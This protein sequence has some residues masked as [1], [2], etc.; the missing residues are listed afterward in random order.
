MRRGMSC[1]QGYIEAC[2]APQ[3]REENQMLQNKTHSTES[4]GKGYHRSS[5]SSR[6]EDLQ[7]EPP[8][9]CR[10]SPV[11][12]FHPTRPRMLGT[13]LV[14]DEVVEVRSPRETRLLT[15]TWVM[16][17]FHRAQLPLDGVMGLIQ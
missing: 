9:S 1:V 5:K 2:Y 13:T 7:I 15:P 17:A 12:H 3:A 10:F 8:V 14:G 4:S 11:F 16:K 6:G